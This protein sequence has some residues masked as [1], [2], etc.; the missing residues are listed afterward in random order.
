M[1]DEFTFRVE[2]LS[3]L[4]RKMEPKT[5]LK[6]LREFF[7]KA[8]IG[9]QGEMRG[10]APKDTGRLASS[11]GYA[12]DTAIPPLWAKAGPNVTYAPYMEH[13]TGTL[14]DGPGGPQAPHWPPG[15]ALDVWAKRHGFQSGYQVARIIGRRGGLKPRRFMRDALVF[16]KPKIRRLAEDALAAIASVWGR[17]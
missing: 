9:L 17:R 13:G 4:L 5:L 12:V 2:G 6:P 16:Q 3:E 10:L 7:T 14:A 11:I 15:P 8:S 1:S